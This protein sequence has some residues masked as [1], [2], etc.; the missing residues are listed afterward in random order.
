MKVFLIAVY[1]A[2][3]VRVKGIALYIENFVKMIFTHVQEYSNTGL[4]AVHNFIATAAEM[5]RQAIA[6]PQKFLFIALGAVLILDIALAGRIGAFGFVI[7]SILML[8]T[9]VTAHIYATIVLA[10]AIVVTV[11]IFKEIKKE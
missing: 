5:A 2:I 1:A 8:L 3:L 11:I 10:L 6:T 7:N 4:V 9:G